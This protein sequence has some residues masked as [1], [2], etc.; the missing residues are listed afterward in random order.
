LLAISTASRNKSALPSITRT[1]PQAELFHRAIVGRVAKGQRVDCPEIT[2]KDADGNALKNGHQHAHILP[3]DLDNDG[4]LDHILIY[5]SMGLG[6]AAQTAIRSM[7]R[8]WTKGGVG[9]LQT[10]LVGRG[11]L[12]CLRQL[13]ESL[14]PQIDKLMAPPEK[15]QTWISATP[16]VAPRHIKRNG[17]NT[18]LCQVNAELASRKL[19]AA[20]EVEVLRPGGELNGV[21]VQKLRHFKRVRQHGSSPP[22]SDTGFALRL[23]LQ[24][25]INGPLTLGYGSHFGLGLFHATAR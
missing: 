8:T 15:S 10:S 23:V 3:L 24:S 9:D 21:N 18:L 11:D 1:L 25:P 16:F 17:K 2:G 5:S 4:H 20:T 19:P 22:P 13:P 14:L 7:K 6:D 12:E